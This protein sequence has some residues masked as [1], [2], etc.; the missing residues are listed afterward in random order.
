MTT[1]GLRSGDAMEGSETTA[2]VRV[3]FFDKKGS[4]QAFRVTARRWR[5][6]VKNRL[7]FFSAAQGKV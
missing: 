4:A 1:K 2:G 3:A 5:L 7:A 6:S